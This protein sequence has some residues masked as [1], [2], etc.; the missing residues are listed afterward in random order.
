MSDSSVDSSVDSNY[1][2]NLLSRISLV[3]Q[4]VEDGV[5]LQPLTGMQ[6]NFVVS[7]LGLLEY[8]LEA[9]EDSNYGCCQEVCEVKTEYD[10][11]GGY[12]TEEDLNKVA[13]LTTLSN[14]GINKV[15]SNTS[16]KKWWKSVDNRMVRALSD[17]Y[18]AKLVNWIFDFLGLQES[19][20]PNFH[21]LV[22][23]ATSFLIYVVFGDPA[24][25]LNSSSFSSDKQSV[26]GILDVIVKDVLGSD[27]SS[28]RVY[29]EDINEE[30]TSHFISV[31]EKEIARDQVAISEESV[32]SFFDWFVSTLLPAI[33]QVED[34]EESALMFGD[35]M[36]NY[37]SGLWILV[38]VL[39]AM[40]F[41]FLIGG[42]RAKWGYEEEPESSTDNK[43][44][45]WIPPIGF[46]ETDRPELEGY[47][48]LSI[49]FYHWGS[50]F[51]SFSVHKVHITQD[52]NVRVEFN[53]PLSPS[54]NVLV[55][56]AF[57][58]LDG[59][60]PESV[61]M[62]TDNKSVILDFQN[63]VVWSED[64]R[65]I[66]TA[67]VLGIYNRSEDDPL[68]V[69]VR[70][71]VYASAEAAKGRSFPEIVVWA[72]KGLEE[73][74]SG[75]YS[76]G[77]EYAKFAFDYFIGWHKRN[78]GPELL[79]AFTVL[80][81]IGWMNLKG[82]NFAGFLHPDS[83]CGPVVE[84]L[85]CDYY[86][87]IEPE[88]VV[89][90]LENSCG[91]FDC[92]E[93]SED[94][95]RETIEDLNNRIDLLTAEIAEAQ[96]TLVAI[97]G[98]MNAEATEAEGV[99]ESLDASKEYVDKLIASTGT[100]EELKL[101]LSNLKAE[102]QTL[103][104]KANDPTLPMEERKE[105]YIQRDAK[106]TEISQAAEALDYLQKEIDKSTTTQEELNKEKERLQNSLTDLQAEKDKVNA[107]IETGLSYKEKTRDA[108]RTNED[109]LEQI[110]YGSWSDVC[111]EAS[112]E[113]IITRY[114]G[115]GTFPA[116][117]NDPLEAGILFAR[118]VEETL[119]E[120][121]IRANLRSAEDAKER[122]EDGITDTKKQM[123]EARTAW[124]Q[125]RKEKQDAIDSLNKAIE[126]FEQG[127]FAN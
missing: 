55:P 2:S 41:S 69:P 5:E 89:V 122:A 8:G 6:R 52:N 31:Q 111:D 98:K 7:V 40:S 9:Y 65:I 28:W 36:P 104:N 68:S 91:I 117:T 21:E 84:E 88:C 19:D 119:S 86:N 71:P 47:P 81:S 4:D 10:P 58:L 113:T 18:P 50:P 85:F 37:P 43:K 59:P 127:R 76:D 72:A 45:K 93:Q 1:I 80:Q 14:L 126:V 12:S 29:L 102:E 34:N 114:D 87:S 95:V 64:L 11:P 105:F 78:L 97:D 15:P 26:D 17:E 82:S 94:S 125:E 49:F 30:M 22:Y 100:V 16:V 23:G 63:S 121:S 107:E 66:F 73:D 42:A 13:I 3:K 123:D 112:E 115:A 38:N 51:R 108:L 79:E 39:L 103:D 44:I 106:R 99:Q 46:G 77:G 116:G 27:A 96:E 90:E 24:I 109:R 124:E 56:N 120:A 83:A 62:G 74:S 32:Y 20:N 48:P 53:Q 25:H 67:D 75:W 35:K 33:N 60:T 70:L 61:Y 118:R 54:A 92:E 110:L 101:S 57:R